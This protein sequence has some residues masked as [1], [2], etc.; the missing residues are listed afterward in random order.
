MGLT[1]YKGNNVWV[2]DSGALDHLTG[3]KALINHYKPTQGNLNIKIANKTLPRVE[4]R[5]TIN[6]YDIVVLTNV[7]YG[8]LIQ[9]N[10]ISI[11]RLNSDL[12]CETK[13]NKFGCVF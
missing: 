11:S 3:N 2:I 8:S 5:G 1:A 13:F 12:N 10:L 4:G 9:Y 6:I 7:L